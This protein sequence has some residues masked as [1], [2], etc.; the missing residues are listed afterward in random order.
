MRFLK[1]PSQRFLSRAPRLSFRLTLCR[2]TRAALAG[3]TLAAGNQSWREAKEAGITRAVEIETDG[4]VLIVHKRRD[5][6][7]G[8]ER[9]QR[10]AY[11]DNRTQQV[12]LDFDPDVLLEEQHLLEGLFYE[13]ELDAL[14]TLADAEAQVERALEGGT[15]GKLSTDRSKVVTVVLAVS[16]LATFERAL[17]A[18][19]LHNRGAALL[20]LCEAYLER[21]AAE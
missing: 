6:A 18:T 10:L 3:D 12:D 21:D 13:D 16:D 20:T 4:D 7:P 14:R 15:A 11:Y 19:G 5:L 8:S 2:R 1:R 9:R 17:A